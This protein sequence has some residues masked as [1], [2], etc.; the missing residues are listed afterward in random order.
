VVRRGAAVA[1]R[2]FAADTA[3]ENSIYR[4]AE[5]GGADADDGNASYPRE[6]ER[7]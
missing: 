4:R 2:F 1:Q 6:R 7:K 5:T 3:T